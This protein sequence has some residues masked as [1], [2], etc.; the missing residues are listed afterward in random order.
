MYVVV[1]RCTDAVGH[2]RGQ[3]EVL[4]I[5]AAQTGDPGGFSV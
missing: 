4:E 1:M 2:T 5:L 3:Q